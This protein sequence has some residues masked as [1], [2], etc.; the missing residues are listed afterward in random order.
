MDRRQ[1]LSGGISL[2]M[3]AASARA[4]ASDA[5]AQSA[6]RYAEAFA[7]LD[8]FVPDYLQSMNAPGLTLCLAD[9]DGVQRVCSYGFDELTQ[10]TPLGSGKLFQ[11]GSISKSFLGLCLMQLRDEGKLD[12]HRPIQEYLPWLR[13]D[14]AGQPLTAHHL[15]THSGALPDGPLF[16]ADPAFRHRATA[17]PGSFFHYCNMGY[18]ALGFLL[19]QLD[20]RPLMDSLRARILAP[21]NMSATEP[22]ITL[23]IHERTVGSYQVT[24]SDRPYPRQGP[25]SRSP[26]LAITDASGCIA[27]T[28]R[29]MGAYLT[30][31]IHRGAAPKGRLVSQEG[32]E[33]FAHPHM[34]A[35]EFGPGAS[36]GY[37]IATDQL[38]GRKRLRHTGG[39]VS[40]V[41]ALQVDLDT[42]VGA[43][44]SINASQ[45][46]RPNPVAEYALRL[47]RA[48]RENAKLPDSPVLTS[49]ASV[50]A[51]ADY[52][53]E[54]SAA[55]GGIL[56]MVARDDRLYLMHQQ[57]PVALEQAGTEGEFFVLHPDYAHFPLL[58]SR[59]GANGKGMV[60][61]AAWGEEWYTS[62][63]YQGPRTFKVPDEWLR[64]PGHYR[65]E[66]PWIGSVRIVL[67][68]GQLWMNGSVP[69]EPADNGRFYL[70]D[71]PQ[72]PEWV[73]FSEFVN[74]HARLLRLSGYVL[75]RV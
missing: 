22:G 57:V 26:L 74:G 45:G 37:G 53:G 18:A 3:V 34:A 17:A 31:L 23:D 13:F 56:K 14:N 54:Y 19:E 29:D 44:A 12:L 62:S 58:F 2:G 20:G 16:P 69:L 52:A 73:S 66:D 32:F 49:P 6:S 9:A 24:Y 4:L 5:V 41:S 8:H 46:F 64:Y 68:R 40:F 59:N 28:T 10:R 39:M 36:Y 50:A 63:A 65:T 27:S 72:S 21:L 55:G 43:F 75:T 33:M 42:G 61:E 67:R 71:E 47:M 38:D 15:L 70:R 7:R 48:S 25:L 30:M 35:E 60:S 11:I 1:V 51:A